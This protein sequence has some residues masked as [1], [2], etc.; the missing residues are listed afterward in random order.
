M[1]STIRVVARAKVN[2]LLRVGRRRAD[3]YHDLDTLFQSLEMADDVVLARRAQGGIEIACALD[4]P[5]EKNLAVR[6]AK[7]LLERAGEEGLG[8]SIQLTKRIPVEAGL[9]GGSADAA[10]V[11]VGLNELLGAPFDG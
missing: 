3:G 8:L 11:L 9:G 5:P 1:P 10:A 2:L 4:V 7:L 6:A